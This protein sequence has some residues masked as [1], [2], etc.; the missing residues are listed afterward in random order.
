MNLQFSFYRFRIHRINLNPS[1]RGHT[2][3]TNNGS[4]AC[5]DALR[6]SRCGTLQSALPNWWFVFTLL[7]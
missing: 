1:R 6:L 3:R 5:G 2:V 7:G 4:M